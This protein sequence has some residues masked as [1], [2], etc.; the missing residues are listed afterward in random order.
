MALHFSTS[1]ACNCA[2]QQ[3]QGRDWCVQYSTVMGNTVIEQLWNNVQQLTLKTSYCFSG[4]FVET[5]GAVIPVFTM[6]YTID[7]QF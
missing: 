7:T 4:V 1:F 2:Q 3:A 6:A 5:C